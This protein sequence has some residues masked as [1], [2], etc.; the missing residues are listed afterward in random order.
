MFR[1]YGYA[2]TTVADIA[3]ACGISAANFY[4]FYESKAV[5]NE[6]ITSLILNRQ[7]ELALLI[8]AECRPAAQRPK[9]LFL[10]MHHFTCEQYL[11]QS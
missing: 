4:H 7:E 11:N 5:I 10:D 9:T 6:A 2:E 1:T 3:R 8:A